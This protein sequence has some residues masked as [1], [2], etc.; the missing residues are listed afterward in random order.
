MAIADVDWKR[1][2]DGRGGGGGGGGGDDGIG[3]SVPHN[4]ARYSHIPRLKSGW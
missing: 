2:G 1:S 3:G 4:V